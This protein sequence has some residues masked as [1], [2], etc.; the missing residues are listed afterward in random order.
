MSD[1]RGCENCEYY[2]DCDNYED[3]PEYCPIALTTDSE[4]EEKK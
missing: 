1:P 2:E 3:A 4:E